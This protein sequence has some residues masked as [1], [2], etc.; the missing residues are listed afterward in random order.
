MMKKKGT[1]IV[2]ELTSVK[3]GVTFDSYR[4]SRNKNEGI[5]Y[6][7]KEWC[8]SKKYSPFRQVQN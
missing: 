6:S 8:G 4:I 3:K 7:G 1:D 5:R 2:L